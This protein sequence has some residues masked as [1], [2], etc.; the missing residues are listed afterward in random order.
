MNYKQSMAFL[1]GSIKYIEIEDDNKNKGKIQVFQESDIYGC[2]KFQFYLSSYIL[3]QSTIDLN[4]ETKQEKNNQTNQLCGFN[5]FNQLNI[6][7]EDPY[8]IL[9]HQNLK[10]K[11][12]KI[13]GINQ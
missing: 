1:L 12:I 3:N 7:N 9:D 13:T 10:S 5:M 2:Q 6:L 8:I 11:P 4:F